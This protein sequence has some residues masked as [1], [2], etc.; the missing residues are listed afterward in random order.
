MHLNE[1]QYDHIKSLVVAENYAFDDLLEALNNLPNSENLVELMMKVFGI[2][3]EIGQ[4]LGVWKK[5]R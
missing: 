2:H 3:E 4:A 5:N 1:Q